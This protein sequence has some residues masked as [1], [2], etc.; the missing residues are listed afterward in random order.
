MKKPFFKFTAPVLAILIAIGAVA[1]SALAQTFCIPKACCCSG[2]GTA[3]PSQN[4]RCVAA[5][6]CHGTEPCCQ[7][8]PSLPFPDMACTP[9][10]DS[11]HQ[12]AA[13]LQG[14][15]TIPVVTSQP[16]CTT[17]FFHRSGFLKISPP[18]IFLQTQSFLY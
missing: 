10:F 12:K 9:F 18:P 8:Q 17:S 16:P 3:Q 11:L 4:Y 6:C 5:S 15:V 2:G 1:D 14:L 13:P 7:T